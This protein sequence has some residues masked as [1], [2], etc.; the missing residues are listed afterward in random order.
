MIFLVSILWLIVF[1][2]KLFFWVWLWQLKEYH[3]G[4]FLDHFRTY[5]GKRLIL[6][7][8]LFLK[9]LVLLGIIYTARTGLS[10]IK[11]NLVYFVAILFLIEA[12]FTI[13]HLRQGTFKKP[14]LTRKTLSILNTGVSFEILIIFF[15]FL[16][17]FK[18][19]RFTASLLL[20]DI[21][22]P[23]GF[24]FLVLAFQ[25]LAVILRNRI[26]K[27]AK[28]K[29][30]RFGN[31]LVIGITGS[32][33]KTSTKE[34]LATILSEKFRVL[35][36]KEHQNSEIGISECILDELGP[37]HQI[38]ICEMGAYNRGGIKLLCDI[39]KPKIGIVTGV[40]EQHL[41][42]FG[43]MENLLSAE[44]GKELIDSLPS[45]GMA[46]FNAKNKYC[47]NLYQKTTIK[48]FLY[49][50]SA[51]FPGEENILGAMAVARELGMTE[52][53]ISRACQKIENKFP[54]IQM[55]NGVSGLKIIDATYSANPDG[56]IAHLEYLKTFPGKKVIIMPC[57]IELGK[58][59]KEVHK[60]IGRKIAEVCDLAIITTKDRFKEIKEGAP[61]VLLIENPKE[62]F[63]KIKSF[64]K[65]GDTIL[66][67]SRVPTQLT[68]Q[69][70]R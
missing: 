33:G 38:F 20:L 66:L 51:T 8:L 14:V 2:K 59:S 56:V 23:I 47:R 10:V 5:K 21:L 9:I 26:L 62:I 44:G 41:A 16:L 28:L 63:E 32:Y 6:N 70:I 12:L 37:E 45:S 31:L 52:E 13:R 40:N 15:L 17:E 4:R 18:L 64:T 27:R 61:N 68:E 36:T 1:T 29:R 43:N 48:K 46:F 65:E 57:L 49:G 50:E 60:R 58:A 54:G 25:P 19:T 42:T 53:E 30:A 55:K 39:V 34:F 67:E 24:S 3:I 69:L 22:T 35:K 11:F 7:Y